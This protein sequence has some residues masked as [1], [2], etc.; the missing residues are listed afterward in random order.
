M[1]EAKDPDIDKKRRGGD[2]LA[3]SSRG[4]AKPETAEE[5]SKYREGKTKED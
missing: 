5:N 1:Q 3:D 4:A 2:V